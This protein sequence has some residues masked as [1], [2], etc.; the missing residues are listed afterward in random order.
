MVKIVDVGRRFGLWVERGTVESRKWD[1]PGKAGR[2]VIARKGTEATETEAH[3]AGVGCVAVVSYLLPMCPRNVTLP[4]SSTANHV[5]M[6][7]SFLF[8]PT[9]QHGLVALHALAELAAWLAAAGVL[10]WTLRQYDRPRRFIALPETVGEPETDGD[11]HSEA[12]H[13]LRDAA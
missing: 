5:T 2:L 6:S 11:D 7:A 9:L 8:N 1:R 10:A 13:D 3:S 4:V 12:E